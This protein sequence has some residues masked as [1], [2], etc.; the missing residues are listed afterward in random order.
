MHGSITMNLSKLFSET[1]VLYCFLPKSSIIQ[2]GRMDKM[3][4]TNFSN[5]LESGSTLSD[6]FS[7]DPSGNHQFQDTDSKMELFAGMLHRMASRAQPLA[8][9]VTLCDLAKEIGCEKIIVQ[10]TTGGRE[11]TRQKFTYSHILLHV[12]DKNR[13]ACQISGSHNCG[14]SVLSNITETS[15]SALSGTTLQ[16]FFSHF[17]GQHQTRSQRR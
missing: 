6:T 11:S 10:S 8:V 5:M 12:W 16:L 2:A 3:S 1:R 15:Q 13:R 4:D 17:L 7:L 14:K 9:G